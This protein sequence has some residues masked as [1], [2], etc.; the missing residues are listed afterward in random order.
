M[1]DEQIIQEATEAVKKGHPCA[2]LVQPLLEVIKRKKAEIIA[3]TEEYN[4][5]LEQ[6]NKVEEALEVKTMDVNSLTSERDALQEMVVE[7]KAENERLQ[8]ERKYLQSEYIPELERALKN[9][10]ETT[11]NVMLENARLQEA[12]TEA[13][14]EFAEKVKVKGTPVTGGKGFEGVYVMCSNIVIDNTLKE[15]TD[16]KNHSVSLIDG[17]IDE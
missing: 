14:R 12:K 11:M 7:Q 13:Y 1:T 3:K 17:H 6:R 2:F 15:L 8:K 16:H 10:D 9:L 5:M 4:D